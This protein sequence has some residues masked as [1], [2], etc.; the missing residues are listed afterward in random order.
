MG[1]SFDVRIYFGYR[2]IRYSSSPGL[3]TNSSH[4][5]KEPLFSRPPVVEHKGET[6]SLHRDRQVASLSGYSAGPRSEAQLSPPVTHD[7]RQ[8][9]YDPLTGQPYKFDPFTGEPIEPGFGS[10]QFRR[11]R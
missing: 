1:A 9:R 10:H 4:Y 3:Y 8:I 5:S 6:A 7:R 11:L 2:Y